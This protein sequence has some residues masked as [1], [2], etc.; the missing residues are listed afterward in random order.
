MPTPEKEQPGVFDVH[1]QVNA[2]TGITCV[3]MPHY[4]PANPQR[5]AKQARVRACPA[6][7]PPAA[8]VARSDAV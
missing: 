8:P 4:N 5:G 7:P 1:V 2:A 6:P 3:N